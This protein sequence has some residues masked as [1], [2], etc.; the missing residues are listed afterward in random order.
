ME[1]GKAFAK[2]AEEVGADGI[3]L[4]P[5][6]LTECPQDGLVEYARQICDATAVNVIYYN[7]GNGILNAS[8]VQQLADHC[9]NL[10]GL[11]DGKGDIQALNKIVKTVGDRLVY[12]GGVPTAEILPRPMSPLA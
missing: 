9:P 5:P 7:R 10:V 12:I 2:A 4:M 11:K 6:Y 8:S 3:L 1:T